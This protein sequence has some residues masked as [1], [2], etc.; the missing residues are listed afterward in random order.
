MK[1]RTMLMLTLALCFIGVGVCFASDL[2]PN[3]GTWTLNEAKSKIPPG[4]LKNTT[5]VYVV[6]GDEIK[7]TTDGIDK[8]GKP[9][10]TEWTGKFDG[11][12]YPLSGDPSSDSR[13]YTKVNEHRL[14]VA[15]KKNG[16]V[17]TSG[18]IIVSADGK[19]RVLTI[20]G[21]DSTGK[22]VSSRAVYDKQ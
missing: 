22:K 8:D 9:A 19:S 4:V 17:T 1:A 2:N 18:H 7:V 3:I 5:V 10:H 21:I 13:S 14:A 16:T 11:K 6:V 20:T 15:N 12:D